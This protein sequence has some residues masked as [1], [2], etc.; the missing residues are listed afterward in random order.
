MKTNKFSSIELNRIFKTTLLL[1]SLIIFSFT[2]SFSQC[3]LTQYT[4]SGGGNLCNGTRTVTVSMVPGNQNNIT[5]EL[6]KNGAASGY[7]S[8]IGTGSGILTWTIT[9]GVGTFTVRAKTGTC[10]QTMT[11]SVIVTN[12]Q[13]PVAT[14]TPSGTGCSTTLTGGGGISYT[15]RYNDPNGTVIATTQSLQPKKG[16]TFYLT[17]TNECGNTNQVSY[18]LSG[19]TRI[20]ITP[21]GSPVNTCPAAL[22]LN[23]SGGTNYQW[24]LP[25]GSVVSASSIVVNTAGTYALTGTNACSISD[26]S[27]LAVSMLPVISPAP[28]TQ[29]IKVK[30]SGSAI[31]TASGAGTN[32]SYAWYD[33]S[34]NFL[35][36]GTTYTTNNLSQNI[37]F[38]VSK[39]STSGTA[40]PSSKSPINVTVNKVPTVNAGLSKTIVLPIKNTYLSGTASDP[41]NDPLTY[42][43]LISSC[44]SCI[45]SGNFTLNFSVSNLSV[46]S[47]VAQLSVFD[48]YDTATDTAKIIVNEPPNN[49]NW[50]K[51]TTV[52]VA[53]ETRADSVNALSIIK[54]KK[55][56]SI[57]Y[58]DGI[59]RPVQTVSVQASPL[60]KDIVVP[61]AYDTYGRESRKY[62]PVTVNE[63]NGYYKNNKAIID[64]N[65]GNYTGTLAGGFYAD[66]R[67]FS[68]LIFEQ[69]P[70]NRPDK[71][72]GAGEAWGPQTGGNNKY[73]KLQSL[74]NDETEE[75]I[76]S[77]TIDAVTGL[78]KRAT[79]LTGYIGNYGYYK[80]GQLIITS[81]KDEQGHEI[82]E[83]KNKAGQ[84]ILKKV[85]AVENITSKNDNTQWALTYFI[86]DDFGNLI[87]ALQ[88]VL[89]SYVLGSDSYAITQAD[90]DKLAFQYRYDIKQRM[91]FKKNPGADPAFMVYDKYDR[92][93]FTQDGNQRKD[94][95]GIVNKK[96][97]LFVKY[98]RLN[99]HIMSGVYTHTSVL[100][101]AG[102]A[103][104]TSTLD[105]SESYNGVASTQGYTNT[106]F[107]AAT[108]PAPNFKVLSVT[109]YDTYSFVTDLFGDNYKYTPNDVPSQEATENT[110]VRGMITGAKIN[111]LSSSNFLL[112]VTYYDKKY[113]VIQTKN[114]NH[115]SGI[116]RVTNIYDFVKLVDSKASHTNNTTTYTQERQYTYDHILRPKRIFHKLQN[117]P[118]VLLTDNNYN[119][120]G[121][122]IKERLHS[123][124]N[125]GSFAQNADYTYNIRGW[126]N[127]I[128]DVTSTEAS[129][130]FSMD[131]GYNASTS[132]GGPQQYGG[133]ISEIIWKTC[134][135]DKQSYGYKYDAMNR[136]LEANYFNVIRPLNNGRYTE[137]I[138]D[139]SVVPVRPSYD[140]NGNI[141]NLL[142]YGKVDQGTYGLVDDMKYVANGTNQIAKIDEYKNDSNFD[143]GFKGN[144]IDNPN[145][146]IYDW[147]GNTKTDMNKGITVTYNHLNLPVTVSKGSDNIVFTYDAIGTKLSQQMSGTISKTT[148]YLG[149]YVYENDILQ[150]VQHEKGRI[151]PDNST[152]APHPWE[153][154]Y[155]LKDH[156]GNIRVLFS[157]KTNSIEFLATM[158]KLPVSVDN[159]ENAK[160]LNMNTTKKVNQHYHSQAYSYRVSGSPGE[161]IGPAKSFQVNAGDIF[162]VES[163]VTY[164][165]ASST[166]SDIGN[167]LNSLIGAFGL[168]SIGGSGIDGP[169]AYSA[170]TSYFPTPWIKS[171]DYMYPTAPKAFVNYLLFDQNFNL[172]DL[173]FDQVDLTAAN[174]HDYLSLNIKVKQQGYLYIYLSNENDKIIP[175]F[176]DDFR[177]I[178]RFNVNQISEYYA[179]GLK[180]LS[181]SSENSGIKNMYLYNGKELQDELNLGW[182]DFGWRNYDPALGRFNVIDNLA[183]NYFELT[184]YQYGSNN[185]IKYVDVNGD[186][187]MLFKNGSYVGI[188]DDGKEEITGY[189]QE[190][191]TDECGN[192]TFTGEQCFSF[193][194]INLDKDK[195]K[196]GKMKLHF[197]SQ[198]DVKSIIASSGVANQNV[199]SRWT[200]AATQSN[201]NDDDGGDKMDFL[202]YDKQISYSDLN[203]ING[204]GYNMNDAGNYLWGYAMGTMGFSSIGAR[205]IAQAYSWWRAKLD[206]KGMASTATNPFVRWYENRSWGGDA[207]ADQRAIQNGLD[208]SGRYKDAKW[209]SIKKLWE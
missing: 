113:R 10:Y 133:N 132:N 114:L 205:G 198:K 207:E 122:L 18:N 118:F 197:V 186:S 162:D 183:D 110:K 144:S 2:E 134:G 151:L 28:V 125:G 188:H 180:Q 194:D 152:G 37:S 208:D 79:A 62:L 121:Q 22:T 45:T 91:I 41:D 24:T 124:D 150:L 101:Q 68:E 204:V 189:N 199:F 54:G 25:G 6:M 191:T 87:F 168:H 154:Q 192:E 200:Y 58:Y 75:K 59:G 38:N 74:S 9:S 44:G 71:T 171:T 51:E 65:T 139:Y 46:G 167:F 99:R 19:I 30:S 89:S 3:G 170:F 163:F 131:L 88:P 8:Q 43:W 107:P 20:A 178:Q 135:Q 142:R 13:T 73:Q 31:L 157:E 39:Y 33:A 29:N 26:N 105:I 57:K 98:D 146:Y 64:P 94:A 190:S 202:G 66:S 100:D 123:R 155:F 27:S 104:L 143:D 166:G 23:A 12:Q 126:I 17:A 141:Q 69:S 165:T 145:E 175:L 106:A 35:A 80:T 7:P 11:G 67:P 32:E 203:I 86:Y 56:V 112:S 158:E 130:L 201:S 4:V 193:N 21:N 129:D 111:I 90:L 119:E 48:G 84:V 185:P 16:G 164:E 49:F 156:L 81:L 42:S 70:A 136:L 76:V 176:F 172:V 85:Q 36:N 120:I 160:F 179:F 127:K 138:G 96:D 72:F 82:R 55:N 108:F 63:A 77:W 52:L 92:V 187:L 174:A 95:N 34:N 14:I 196:K 148:D 140:L 181:N 47:Y 78:P 61:I 184:P 1:L 161:V 182:L 83:Y 147:N 149:E 177:I 153:Y 117:E 109:Y 195:L 116:D 93:I 40:C 206:N 15:W 173:G 169:Q 102:M 50:F 5:Y 115:K 209:K 103:G 159:D 137:K 53:N 128:N 97:W 60:G